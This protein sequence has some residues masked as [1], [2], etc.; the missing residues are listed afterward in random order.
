MSTTVKVWKQD[1]TIN[2][3]GIRERVLYHPVQSGPC[4]DHIVTSPNSSRIRP[5]RNGLLGTWRKTSHT[6]DLIHTFGVVQSVVETVSRALVRS[7][8]GPFVWK[9]DPGSRLKVVPRSGSG[10]NAYYSPGERSLRFLY[11]RTGRRQKMIYTCRSF[12]VVAHEA[13]HAVLDSLQPLWLFNRSP[14][15]G[16]LHEA[17]G[18]LVSLFALLDDLEMCDAVVKVTGGD[19]RNDTF[20][21]RIADEF[22]IALGRSKGLRDM[23]ND[24]KLSDVSNEVHDLSRPFSAACY[25]ILARIV[26]ETADTSRWTLGETLH[27]VSRRVAEI[28]GGAYLKADPNGPLMYEVA[29]GMLELTDPGVERI[30]FRDEF[31]KRGITGPLADRLEHRPAAQSSDFTRC[32]CTLSSSEVELLRQSKDRDESIG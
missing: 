32:N 16:A 7:G 1:P 12:D 26:D 21:S 6:A 30:A 14:D 28:V 10:A 5:D 24:L 15:V 8:Q 29:T 22:G 18:D 9:W 11:F 19:L 25:Q 17:F 2:E 4:S 27:R 31:A 23:N 20:F 13:G 3:I